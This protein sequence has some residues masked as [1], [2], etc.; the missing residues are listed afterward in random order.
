MIN[1]PNSYNLFYLIQ[2]YIFKNQTLLYIFLSTNFMAPLD[3]FIKS[4]IMVIS[5]INTTST[6]QVP[7][8]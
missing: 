6:T 8:N 7:L 3:N 1:S 5:L 2:K 4:G